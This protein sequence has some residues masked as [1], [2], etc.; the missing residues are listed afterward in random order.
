M[1]D[2]ECG[3][4]PGEGS[5]DGMPVELQEFLEIVEA[6]VLRMLG[7]DVSDTDGSENQHKSADEE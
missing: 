3:R 1:V 4:L 2:E 5:Y 6:I 7:P